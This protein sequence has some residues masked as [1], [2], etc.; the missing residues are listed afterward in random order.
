MLAALSVPFYLAKQ[1]QIIAMIVVGVIFGP[2]FHFDQSMGLRSRPLC[3]QESESEMQ[4]RLKDRD[5]ATDLNRGISSSLR[6]S[7]TA[8]APSIAFSA[9]PFLV[10]VCIIDAQHSSHLHTHIHFRPPS[11]HQR[12]N[13]GEPLRPGHLVRALHGRHGGISHA[14]IHPCR[15]PTA[16]PHWHIH[17]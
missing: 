10:R 1:S 7:L 17:A 11:H 13:C 6:I 3:V 9:T 12:K 16:R 14:A 5:S 8:N 15:G 2:V 4:R